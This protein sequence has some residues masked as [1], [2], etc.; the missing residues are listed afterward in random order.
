MGLVAALA[1]AA[2]TAGYLGWFR[3]SSLV[4]VRDVQI[5]GVS[6]PDSERIETALA[7]AAK[8]MTTLHFDQAELNAAVSGFPT[9][10]SVTGDPS[11]PNGLAIAVR[12]RPPALVVEAP[13]RRLAAA[14]DGTLLR[15]LD[16]GD[17]AERLPALPVRELPG[18]DVLEGEALEQAVVLGAA[19]EPLRPLIESVG[20]ARNHGVEVVLR[21]EFPV[22]FGTKE[23]AAEKWE[24][25]AAVLADPELE[26]LTYVDVRVPERPSVGGAAPAEAPEEVQLPEEVAT[27]AED[28]AAVDPAL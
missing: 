9:V 22:R 6:S 19:P 12:E 20:F 18:G 23:K 1:G 24:A 13:G 8:S 25:A 7:E 3:D 28:P 14:A 26:T 15:G 16:L 4:A 5:T 2:L 11:F 21:G 10:V 17:A 27:V